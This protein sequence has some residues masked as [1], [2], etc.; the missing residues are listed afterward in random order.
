MVFL[1]L[2]SHQAM[3][4]PPDTLTLTDCVRMA[5]NHHPFA[6]NGQQLQTIN[7]LKVKNLGTRWLPVLDLNGQTTYQSDVISLDTELPFPGIEFP[8]PGKDQYKVTLDLR[9]PI[10]E[11]GVTDAMKQLENLEFELEKQQLEADLDQ[12]REQVTRVFFNLLILQR[13]MEL[14]RLTIREM[15][16]KKEVV[17]SGIRNGLLMPA[18]RDVMQAELLKMHQK[19]S[20]FAHAGR[21]GVKILERLTG[22]AYGQDVVLLVP[23]VSFHRDYALDRPEQIV[24]ELNVRKLQTLAELESRK[25][26]PDLYAFG[27]LGYGNPGLNYLQDEFDHFYMVGAGLRW[28]IWDWN[29]SRQERQVLS[30]QQEIVHSR[31]RAFERQVRINMEQ[32]AG[33]IGRYREA[34]EK[35]KELVELRE[36]I[37]A[38]ADSRLENGVMTPADYLEVLNDEMAARITLETRRIQ[39]IQAM[40]LY[41]TMKGDY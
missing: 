30:V 25:R 23:E 7:R 10:Y 24:F 41:N 17:N 35:D 40:V 29:R 18:E 20:G 11:G 16:K 2:L 34:V 3:A 5:R 33:D 14:I 12:V 9:Q 19:L 38:S 31:K 32:V 28:N 36:N 6:G 13:N 22:N 4:Q 8:V 39:L 37:R 1:V 15:E 26:R 27:Q 21:V